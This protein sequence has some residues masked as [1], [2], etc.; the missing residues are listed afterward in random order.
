MIQ[1]SILVLAALAYFCAV[2]VKNKRV[3][4]SFTTVFIVLLIGATVSLVLNEQNHFGMEKVLAKRRSLS[5]QLK[6]VP[7]YCSIKNW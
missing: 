6:R 5:K 4:N 1:I 2:F 7:I 3:G